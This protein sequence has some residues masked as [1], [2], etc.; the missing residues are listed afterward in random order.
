MNTHPDEIAW[1]L[2]VQVA[3][4]LLAASPALYWPLASLLSRLS[5]RAPPKVETS[6][7]VEREMTSPKVERQPLKVAREMTSPKVERDTTSPRVERETTLPRVESEMT[8]RRA[9]LR[10]RTSLASSKLSGATRETGGENSPSKSGVLSGGGP[11]EPP[12]VEREMTLRHEWVARGA[13]AFFLAYSG[14]GCV[15]FCTFLPWT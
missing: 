15:L 4:R 12:K 11:A 8:P 5:R 9:S 2:Q 1:R 6:P 7:K 3:T 13:V 10:S 14:V